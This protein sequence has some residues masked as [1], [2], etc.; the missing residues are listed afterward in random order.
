LYLSKRC[1][2]IAAVVATLPASKPEDQRP[3]DTGTAKVTRES[4]GQG[5]TTEKL[6]NSAR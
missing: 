6:N 4:E 1:A 2:S 5:N 3:M